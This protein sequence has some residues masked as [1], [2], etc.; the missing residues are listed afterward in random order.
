MNRTISALAKPR[1]P[2]SPLKRAAEARG[3]RAEM[4]GEAALAAEGWRILGRR[5]R[6]PFGELDMIA[7]RE[8]MLA[9]V[10][11]KARSSLAQAAEALSPRQC[12]RLTAAAE[13]W[14]GQNPEH[15][16]AGIRFDM[17]LVDNLGQVRRIA[18]AFRPEW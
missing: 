8:G 1:P 4:M 16:A 5:V 3:R 14:C 11:V 15:G 17:V 12:S 10:E 13:F 6:T 7:E 2:A 18:D 9:F